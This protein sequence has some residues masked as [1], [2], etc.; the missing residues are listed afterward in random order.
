M[1]C[2]HI[3]REREKEPLAL[4]PK[5]RVPKLVTLNDTMCINLMHCNLDG[6]LSTHLLGF[7][8]F[9]LPRSPREKSQPSQ[10]IKIGSAFVHPSGLKS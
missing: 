1:K 3:L 7:V 9:M 4:P 6:N 2:M 10:H 8:S 5:I